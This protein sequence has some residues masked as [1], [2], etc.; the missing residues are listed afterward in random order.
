[1]LSLIWSSVCFFSSAPWLAVSFPAD[2]WQPGQ[3]AAIHVLGTADGVPFED[4]YPF[5]DIPVPTTQVSGTITLTGAV[6]PAQT[7]TLTFRPADG[8]PAF[9]HTV[10][11]AADGSYALTGIPAGVY[12]LAVK[13]SR[14]LQK[15]VPLDNTQ[16]DLLH[17][18]ATLT[19]GDAND[20]NHIDIL[21]LGVL[22]DTYNTDATNPDGTPNPDWDPRADFNC[23]GHVDILDLGLLADNYNTDGDP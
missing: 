15:V 14:W 2:A 11:L 22:A 17:A 12:S 23:D 1:M 10:T 20:D 7:V 21:D 9:A 16:G 8:S 13:G 18:D 4:I 19:P 5:S 6:D 3:P